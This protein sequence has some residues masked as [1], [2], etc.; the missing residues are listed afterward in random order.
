M[1]CTHAPSSVTP[2][3]AARAAKS[4]NVAAAASGVA[5]FNATRPTA[6]RC[7]TAGEIALMA[8]LNPTSCAAC[9]ACSAVRAMRPGATGRPAVSRMRATASS[10]I[11]PVAAH[12]VV[13]RKWR[14]FEW[15]DANAMLQI[16]RVTSE[17][18]G[19]ADQARVLGEHHDAVFCQAR[20]DPLRRG[21]PAQADRARRA[22][23]NRLEH[24][25]ECW[26]QA[27][28]SRRE[29]QGTDRCRAH[30]PGCS[31]PPA[32][33]PDFSGWSLN[34]AS[35]RP[36]S[37]MKPRASG[38]VPTARAYPHRAAALSVHRAHIDPSR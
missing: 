11:T 18:A 27:A 33:S 15:H 14:L 35:G 1:C 21:Q 10:V 16:R 29:T 25:G 37:S 24:V 4:R 17:M 19:G 6:A 34:R 30:R 31:T 23:A 32:G 7:V 5:T 36:G 22:L 2:S 38:S 9:A 28:K 8:T 20:N 12:R 26:C 3:S 13:P